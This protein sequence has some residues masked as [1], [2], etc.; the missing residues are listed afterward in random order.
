MKHKNG[1]YIWLEAF[2]FNDGSIKGSYSEPKRC[3]WVKAQDI[4]EEREKLFYALIENTNAVIS[5]I[6]RRQEL[7]EA[8]R[9]RG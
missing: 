3:N 7:F 2:I 1:S 8:L 5:L 6:D 9:Q 4:I